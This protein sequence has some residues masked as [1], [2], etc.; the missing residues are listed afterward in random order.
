MAQTKKKKLKIVDKAPVTTNTV[1]KN[2]IW[3]GLLED[4]SQLMMRKGEVMRS[5][6]YAKAQE[7]ILLS[8]E[9]LT[10]VTQ[11]R[12]KPNIGPTI[13]EK[14]GEF[15]ST[16][17]IAV[18]DREKAEPEYIFTNIYG[19]GPKKAKELVAQNVLTLEQLKEEPAKYLNETQRVGLRY[20]DDILERIPRSEID[21]YNE[22]L[23]ETFELCRVS[24]DDRFEIVGSYRRGQTTSGDIDIIVT[25]KDPK[26][27][28]RWLN[29]LKDADII[30]EVL[31]KGKSKALLISSLPGK[32]NRRLDLLYTKPEE[33]PFSVL[34]FT[35]SKGFNT[36][37]RGHALKLGYS[38]NEY[39]LYTKESGKEKGQ[40]VDY[41]FTSEKDI[42]D[43]LNMEYKSPEQRTDGRAVAA[44][45]TE[46]ESEERAETLS[47]PKKEGTL[48]PLRI[49]NAH[50][51]VAIPLI[52]R[53][54]LGD[55]S[56][57]W[58]KG[59]PYFF[60][61]ISSK[62]RCKIHYLKKNRIVNEP[63]KIKSKRVTMKKN[64]KKNS[65]K[66]KKKNTHRKKTQNKKRKSQKKKKIVNRYKI[67]PSY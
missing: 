34:Y 16:G 45:R 53:P 22:R 5:R 32:K 27:L 40:K 41:P 28:E 65:K 21:E 6:A 3:A 48:T 59:E 11:L 44:R 56:V 26:I 66:G 8:E 17:K 37:M 25:S 54:K 2:E 57:E 36:M 58:C 46:P 49:S 30:Q 35:G 67:I 39:G 13:I 55:L 42:F 10:S 61:L 62:P 31:S 1:R 33:Y 50:G 20:Y 4:L 51:N 9:D 19:V 14:I 24:E 38:L 29:A 12:G 64:S 7:T 15:E 60:K 18:I 52:N 47:P 23:N 63:I 43:F